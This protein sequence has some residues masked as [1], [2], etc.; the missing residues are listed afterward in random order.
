MKREIAE[1]NKELARL[2]KVADKAN[3]EKS[4]FLAMMSH[5]VSNPLTAILGYTDMISE[6]DLADKAK[7]YIGYLTSAGENL[8]VIVMIF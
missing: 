2:R 6:E 1:K 7:E 3:E 5:E 4:R 8:K